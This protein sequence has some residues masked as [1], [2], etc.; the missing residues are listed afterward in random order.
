[1]FGLKG[2]NMEI[3]SLKLKNH[4][5]LHDLELNFCDT[6]GT[7]YKN[8]VFAGENG[9][10]K[11]ALLNLLHN[12]TGQM[13]NFLLTRPSFDFEIECI[14]TSREFDL[15]K[16]FLEEPRVSIVRNLDNKTFVLQ[17][18]HTENDSYNNHIVYLSG[19]KHPYPSIMNKVSSVF[20]S[21]YSKV[22]MNFET[23]AIRS[24]TASQI[25]SV[26]D[27]ELKHT[28]KEIAMLVK[29]LL[30]DISVQDNQYLSDWI[31]MHDGCVPPNEVKHVKLSRFTDAFN[32]M[33][34]S[35]NFHGIVADGNQQQVMFI[36]NGK[37]VKL[38]E[39]SSGE[40]QIVFRGGFLLKNMGVL[41]GS[42]VLIDEPEI[43]MHPRWQ[44]KIF[45]FYSDL[46]KTETEQKSQIFFATHSE[47]V[48][49]EA[50]DNGAKIIV[51]TETDD[52]LKR[53]DIEDKYVLPYG[54]TYAEIKYLAF[55]I[56]TI[57]LHDELY[58][59]IQDKNK[60][61]N[62]K[63][64]EEFFCSC[65]I[66]LCKSWSILSC[67]AFGPVMPSSLMTYIRNYYHHPEAIHGKDNPAHPTEPSEEDMKKSIENMMN[68]LQTDGTL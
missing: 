40:K 43:S 31:D 29:Q 9:I 36:K 44:C 57:E 55:N 63:A 66:E 47:Y 3:A 26:E 21:V 59:Y 33:F 54:P 27:L 35:I 62:V 13:H 50:M 24:I 45:S 38:E 30:I 53:H 51:L 14:L 60:Y 37:Q 6:N 22:G 5:I 2:P 68:I 23:Q 11:T 64:L 1:M 41:D 34:Q 56:P 48:L 20:H 52:G 4:P 15:V 67:G 16:S 42:I 8:I 7:P 32:K 19:E 17:Y 28:N 65:G 18:K 49:K 25:D 61:E 46:F 10:G 39:L 58:G 12:I